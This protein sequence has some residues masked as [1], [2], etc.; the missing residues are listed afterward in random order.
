MFQIGSI[1]IVIIVALAALLIPWR[2]AQAG[3][4]RTEDAAAKLEVRVLEVRI[5]P[6]GGQGDRGS[7][8]Y[9]MEVISVLR[10]DLRVKPGETIVV[11][12]DASPRETP[13]SG[14]AGSGSGSRAPKRLIPGWIGIAYLNP[15]PNADGLEANKRF[16]A[17]AQGESFEDLPPTPPSLR[18]TE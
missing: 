12:A 17:A 9:S 1:R 13:E 11:R 15:A 5:D 14:S 10:A 3:E 16:T 6:D 4:D 2:A 18:W 8:I 7:L